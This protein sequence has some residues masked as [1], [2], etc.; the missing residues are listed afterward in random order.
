[1][2]NI[3]VYRV[4]VPVEVTDKT[5]P[6]VERLEKAFDALDRRVI[7]PRVDSRD[8]D[9]GHTMLSRFSDSLG[10]LNNSNVRV[11]LSLMDN[12]SGPLRSIFQLVGG[13][14]GLVGG[15]A[16]AA[17]S[18]AWPLKL[19]GN[20]EQTL[21]SY[22]TFLGSQEK[23]I[24]FQKQMESLA[25]VSPFRTE[26][27]ERNAVGLLN[28][29]RNAAFTMRVLHDFGDT[30]SATGVGEERMTLSILGFTQIANRGR[31]QTE[32]LNQVTENLGISVGDVGRELGLTGEQMGDLGNQ[33]ISAQRGME[34]ILRVQERMF[35]GGMAMQAK[36]LNGLLS[37]L[38]DTG[39]R[40]VRSFGVGLADELVPRLQAMVGWTDKNKDGMNAFS[41]SLT[42]LGRA[43]M[44]GPLSFLEARLGDF[45]RMISTEMWREGTGPERAK[46]FWKRVITDPFDAWWT[47]GGEKRVQEISG[48]V[49]GAMGGFIGG[50]LAGAIGA[51]RDTKLD[52]PFLKAGLVAGESFTRAFVDA[53]DP[54]RLGKKLLDWLASPFQNGPGI[55]DLI[56]GMRGPG[57]RRDGP[58]GSP[59][60]V[61]A[62]VDWITGGPGSPFQRGTYPDESGRAAPGV[63]GAR[64]AT[65]GEPLTRDQFND[66][67][68]LARFVAAGLDANALANACGPIV[69]AGM[70]RAIGI[71]A[72]PAEVAKQAERAGV[73]SRSAGV[74]DRAHGLNQM[75][76]SVGV[77][78]QDVGLV[79]M[80]RRLRRGEPVAV[81]APN[82]Y[83]EATGID[84]QGRLIVG[85]T[86]TSRKGGRER[87]SLADIRRIE[88]NDIHFTGVDWQATGRALAATAAE[89]NGVDPG[90]I[91][92]LLQQESGFDPNARN[93]TS[94]ARGI[95]Q[96]MPEDAAARGVDPDNPASAI[97]GTA[98]Y[99][100]D[101]AKQYGSVE[102][103]V[104]AYN[105][106][107]AMGKAV[108]EGRLGD[109]YDE[110][111]TMMRRVFPNKGYAMGGVV[112]EPVMGVGVSGQR[113]SFAE[114]GP[115]RVVPMGRDGSG[116]GITIAGDLNVP[117]HASF[118]TGSPAERRQ[119]IEQLRSEIVRML[120][121]TI[122]RGRSNVALGV[123]GT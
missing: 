77:T 15:G 118:T 19:A 97:Q 14:L 69:A 12:A 53:F 36:T 13:P 51:G 4:S 50:A 98:K 87:M 74:L 73:W 116:G 29:S 55:A 8:V 88:G 54:G 6:T 33:N 85:T 90:V 102:A 28:V 34:A 99:I 57:Y 41:Q 65:S 56:P 93:Q 96:W 20:L 70:A 100:A 32:E 24:D 120:G 76:A 83:Y 60:S 61:G 7:R 121:E 59:S 30:A 115:E 16:L 92:R 35:G 91:Q 31:L 11:R 66:P 17:A 122:Q 2:P 52:D 9:R 22:R 47:S 114:N 25:D 94:G 37:T 58:P 106:G 45:N 26:T 43:V 110:T 79:E 80:E 44:G 82:H 101:L 72:D 68:Q 5:T 39:T 63:A 18:I 62:G 103:A 10:R 48:Q 86:G 21:V 109:L 95:G 107:A 1:M 81:N 38:R 111:R 75:L 46:L 119:I 113:Y 42:E 112:S 71:A 84:E 64:S 105:G 49:G 27:L 89:A 23:A 78:G 117:I 40:F 104:A 67:E 3:E 108:Q 123:S